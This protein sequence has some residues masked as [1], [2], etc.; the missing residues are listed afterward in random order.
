MDNNDVKKLFKGLKKVYFELAD[1][2]YI[3]VWGLDD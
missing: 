2:T 1:P 3:L